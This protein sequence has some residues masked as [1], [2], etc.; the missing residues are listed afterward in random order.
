[1]NL[2]LCRIV[3]EL[4]QGKRVCQ[5]Q[6]VSYF[7]THLTIFLVFKGLGSWVFLEVLDWGGAKSTSHYIVEVLCQVNVN[8]MLGFAYIVFMALENIG[9]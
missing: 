6:Q 5:S 8:R 3:L 2:I 9:E 1:M 7:Q 4:E